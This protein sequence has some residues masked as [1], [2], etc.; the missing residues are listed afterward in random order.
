MQGKDAEPQDVPGERLRSKDCCHVWSG[1]SQ[2][3]A[4]L[5]SGAAGANECWACLPAIQHQL[6]RLAEQG[7]RRAQDLQERKGRRGS[8]E[9]RSSGVLWQEGR[10]DLRGNGRG[11]AGEWQG[12][13]GCVSDG[14]A[15]LVACQFGGMPS[16]HLLF[17]RARLEGVTHICDG[18]GK[19]GL[20][21]LKLAAVPGSVTA[22]PPPALPTSAS[23]SL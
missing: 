4:G 2:L 10:D 15:S 9:T 12:C 16:P 6:E 11:M 5:F 22:P 14:R 8:G 13:Q 23:A 20:L 21:P 19:L 7:G 18:L 3:E 1:G 17:S